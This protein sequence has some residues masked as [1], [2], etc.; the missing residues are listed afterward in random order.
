MSGNYLKGFG[1]SVDANKPIH[2][3]QPSPSKLI[4]KIIAEVHIRVHT[5]Y[6]ANVLARY[7]VTLEPYLSPLLCPLVPGL[8][9]LQSQ[10]ST[11]LW[12]SVAYTYSP[13]FTILIWIFSQASDMQYTFLWCQTATANPQLWVNLVITRVNHLISIVRRF[14]P[15]GD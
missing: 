6:S 10:T 14:C 15:S 9:C 3:T 4:Q 11:I 13:Q 8:F 7:N 5:R 1:K 2:M 12:V